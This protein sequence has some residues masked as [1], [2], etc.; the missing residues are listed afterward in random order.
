MAFYSYVIVIMSHVGMEAMKYIV[1]SHHLEWGPLHGKCNGHGADRHMY[2]QS[3]VNI[4]TF[5]A[6]T[7]FV[8]AIKV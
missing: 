7:Y 4:S 6:Q 8:Y 3:S 1:K 2:K 5:C